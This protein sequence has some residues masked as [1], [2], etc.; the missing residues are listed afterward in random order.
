[1]PL[2]GMISRLQE[3]ARSRRFRRLAEG[4]AWAALLAFIVWRLAPQI[5]AALGVGRTGEPAPPFTVVTLDGERV[6]LDSLRGKVVLLNFWATWCAPCRIEM[7]GF[8]RVYRDKKDQGFEIVALST[9]QEGVEKV[10]NYIADRGVTFPVAMAPG[11]IVQTY[12]GGNMIPT[13]ILIDRNGRI[14]HR[15]TGI[16]A[17]PAL[18]LAVNRLLAEEPPGV[19]P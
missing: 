5:G 2:P 6:S 17:E 1:M 3:A 12:R 4:I 19:D 10:V 16:F 18:R 7:P 11:G 9:D 14:R 13:S 15:V 8:Q